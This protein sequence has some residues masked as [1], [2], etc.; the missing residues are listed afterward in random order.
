MRRDEIRRIMTRLT[1]ANG[2]GQIGR[3]IAEDKFCR[4]FIALLESGKLKPDSVSLRGLWE[5]LVGPAEETLMLGQRMTNKLHYVHMREETGSTAFPKVT[6]ALIA[7]KVIEGY[8][9]PNSM[10]GDELVEPMASRLKTETI[11]GFNAVEGPLDVEEGEEY[12]DSSIGEKYVT[13]TAQKRGRII[14]LTEELIFFDQTGQVTRRAMRLGEKA[15]LDRENRIIKGVTGADAN[16]YKPSGT[17]TTLYSTGHANLKASNA[18]V[19]WTDIDGVMQTVAAQTDENG[20]KIV[21]VPDILLVG[22]AKRFTALRIVN[23]TEVEDRPSLGTGVT[24]AVSGN[25][26]RGSGIRVL[27]SPL[28]DS[29]ITAGDFFLTQRRAFGYQ[30]VWP[31]QTL[32]ARQGHEDEFNRD[33]VFKYKVREFGNVFCLDHRLTYKSKEAS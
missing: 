7:A 6:G 20:D 32:V 21:V 13:T 26:L 10:I 22:W 24:A 17:A 5:G 23:A 18:L 11:T 14:S 4:Q 3:R 15:R 2:G 29:H 28:V 12:Q 30:E 1:E 33:V 27:S 9:L 19:D 16:V 31:L 25:P 8:N